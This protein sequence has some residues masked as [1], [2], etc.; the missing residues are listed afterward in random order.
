MSPLDSGGGGHGCYCH[1]PLG[2]DRDSGEDQRHAA[3]EGP[4]QH[5]I[6]VAL[7]KYQN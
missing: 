6:S 1:C 3:A 2:T 7:F 4:C 5:I